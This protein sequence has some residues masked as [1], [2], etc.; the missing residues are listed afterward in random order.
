MKTF[1]YSFV[2]ALFLFAGCGDQKKTASK[3]EESNKPDPVEEL[4]KQIKLEG[5]HTSYTKEKYGDTIKY[6]LSNPEKFQYDIKKSDSLIYDYEAVVEFQYKEE[7]PQ[8]LETGVYDDDGK[9][10]PKTHNLTKTVFYNATYNLVF[11][12]GKWFAKTFSLKENFKPYIDNETCVLDK[13]NRHRLH[14][15]M[16]NV[17]P[18]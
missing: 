4:K 8:V 16:P 14:F 10:V 11:K 6:F 2:I 9:F 1:C 12:N 17:N 18:E 5:P 7:T 15:V 13:N 3:S